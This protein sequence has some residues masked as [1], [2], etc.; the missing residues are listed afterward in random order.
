MQCSDGLM[1]TTVYPYNDLISFTRSVLI[2]LI[3]YACMHALYGWL[4]MNACIV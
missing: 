4:H 3:T 1:Y 2:I